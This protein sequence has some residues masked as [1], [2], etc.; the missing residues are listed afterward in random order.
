MGA[1]R[2]ISGR[3]ISGLV[4]SGYPLLPDRLNVS[5]SGAKEHVRTGRDV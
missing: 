3:E 1:L 4:I 5:D 2:G